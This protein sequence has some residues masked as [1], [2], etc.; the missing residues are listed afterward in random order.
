MAAFIPQGRG[1][2]QGLKYFL[3]GSLHKSL[4]ISAPKES[5]AKSKHGNPRGL[6]EDTEKEFRAQK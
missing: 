3:F 1:R 5:I 6:Q 2:L 4:S